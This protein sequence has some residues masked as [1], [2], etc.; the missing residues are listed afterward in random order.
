M[1]PEF[2]KMLSWG[3]TPQAQCGCGRV[4]YTA[5]GD[6]MDPGELAGLEAK[7]KE[8]PDRYIPT[9]DDSVSITDVF[10]VTYIWDCPCEW[11]ERMERKLWANRRHI[12]TYYRDRT[13]R[14]LDEAN[15]SAKAL[16]GLPPSWWQRVKTKLNPFRK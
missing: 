13:Q 7:R 14:E 11:A 15:A 4:H 6:F 3:G 10:G 12:I 9:T 1:T 2:E 16:D 5:G 8:K